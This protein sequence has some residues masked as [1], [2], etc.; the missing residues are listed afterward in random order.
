ML[1]NRGV[2][3]QVNLSSFTGRQGRR[4]AT[5]AREMAKEGMIDFL[6]SDLHRPSQV[7]T[8]GKAAASSKELRHLLQNATLLNQQL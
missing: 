6:G 2:K 1:R 3:M 7:A 4:A 5:L 8:V